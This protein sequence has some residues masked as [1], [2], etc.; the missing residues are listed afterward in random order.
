MADKYINYAALKAAETIG[1]D[2]RIQAAVQSDE[3]IIVSPHA[4][5]IEVATTE[6]TIATAGNYTSYYLFEGLKSSGNGVLHITSTHFDEPFA[7][8]MME[9]HNFGLSYHGFKNEPGENREYTIIGGMNEDL[10]ASVYQNLKS[11]GFDVEYAT[12]RF[13][14]KD[15][16][17]IV[18]RAMF[19]GVQLELS[20][21]QRKAFFEG[22]D[23]SKDNRMNRTDAFY[24]YVTAVKYALTR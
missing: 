9:K 15:P 10:Q 19:G 12:D 22:G 7:L 1:V 5:G 18:N 3:F 4:G 6:L 23:W 20:T 16:N 17:N 8:H 11:C 2:Y 13:T 21:E 24:N 14:A